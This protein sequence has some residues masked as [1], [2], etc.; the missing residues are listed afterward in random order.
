MC[1]VFPAKLFLDF[2][3]GTLAFLVT[4]SDIVSVI[5]ALPAKYALT[6]T[7]ASSLQA[8]AQWQR[9]GWFSRCIMCYLTDTP[10]KP[11]RIR[12]MIIFH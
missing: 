7:E 12:V 10:L 9:F 5:V 1:E 2:K 6:F 4:F 8:I 11:I 3:S